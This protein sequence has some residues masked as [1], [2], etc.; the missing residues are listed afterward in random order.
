[1]IEQLIKIADYLDGI[2]E[3]EAAEKVD[4]LI[5]K[6]ANENNNRLIEKLC[7]YADAMDALGEHKIA[8]ELDAEVAK[9]S[10]LAYSP[11]VQE[12]DFSKYD[13]EKNNDLIRKKPK[14]KR[15]LLEEHE[16]ENLRETGKTMSTRDCPDH[17]GTMMARVG[18]NTY[19]CPRDGKVYNWE[20]GWVDMSG[21]KH[22]G[23]SIS[24]QTTESIN[25]IIPSRIFE[26]R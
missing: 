18:E 17:I 14:S 1:M 24:G 3:L 15:E 16:M 8:N 25:Y 7:S 12:R 2:G 19:Q 6:I 26:D 10:K 11:D 21:K 13:S 22:P 4:E 5:G 20:E 23:G 9:L